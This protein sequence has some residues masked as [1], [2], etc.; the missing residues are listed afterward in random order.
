MKFTQEEVCLQGEIKKLKHEL[1]IA[2][3]MYK[4]LQVWNGR[5]KMR[6]RDLECKKEPIFNVVLSGSAK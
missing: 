5:Q 1:E 3:E 4:G 2:R 6:I